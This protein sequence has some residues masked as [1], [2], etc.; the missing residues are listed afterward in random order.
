MAKEENLMGGQLAPRAWQQGSGWRKVS[1]GA[2]LSEA[3]QE[4]ESARKRRVPGGRAPIPGPQGLPVLDWRTHVLPLLVDPVAG[5]LKLQERYGDI[6]S[7]GRSHD[8]PVIVF[9]PEYI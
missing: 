6:V 1:A 2:E 3:P 5:M 8:A 9:A 7:L 4:P